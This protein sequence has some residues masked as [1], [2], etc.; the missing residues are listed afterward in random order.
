MAVQMGQREMK[1]QRMEMLRM[2]LLE[3]CLLESKMQGM[4]LLI[5]KL[6][7]MKYLEICLLGVNMVEDVGV[8]GEVRNEGEGINVPHET[9]YTMTQMSKAATKMW[10]KKTMPRNRTKVPKDAN[11]EHMQ[12]QNTTQASTVENGQ[13]PQ[14]QTSTFDQVGAGDRN[15]AGGRGRGGGGGRGRGRGSGRGSGRGVGVTSNLEQPPHV[16]SEET[17]L[18]PQIGQQ[19][20]RKPPTANP[21]R[22]TRSQ[23]EI[24]SSS[25][26]F[27]RCTK[28][29][30]A[31]TGSSSSG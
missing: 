10:K 17:Q 21:T 31:D 12:P 14:T 6:P 27:G 29:P 28:R 26:A 20:R 4:K 23:S 22:R 15:V 3:I 2:K 9:T 5:M 13:S 8:N 24:S 11:P 16:G 25:V 7:R 18:N 19:S 1:A 30:K